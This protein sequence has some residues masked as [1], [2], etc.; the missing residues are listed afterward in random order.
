[1]QLVNEYS[2]ELDRAQIQHI[3]NKNS[4]YIYLNSSPFYDQIIRLW[5]ILKVQITVDQLFNYLQLADS[6]RCFSFDYWLLLITQ[7]N[8][9]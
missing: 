2:I 8:G 9:K 1:M 3:Y 5:Q 4:F 6:A 7:L